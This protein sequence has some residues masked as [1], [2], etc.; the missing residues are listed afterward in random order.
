M[1]SLRGPYPTLIQKV[2][3]DPYAIP[4]GKADIKRAG[5]DITV[6][7]TMMM[8]HKALRVAEELAKKG[9]S[10]EVIDPR[11]LVPLDKRVIVDSV[12]KTGKVVVVSEDVK[13]AGVGAEIATTIMEEAF[14]YLDAP[15]RRVSALD[16]PIPY[17]PA[18]ESTVIPQEKHITDAVLEVVAQK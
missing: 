12:K 13:T 15:V 14:D 18:L 1:A 7:A 6:V 17:A 11:T 16:V 9:V 8:V 2:P 5:E 4:F 10:M 3:E